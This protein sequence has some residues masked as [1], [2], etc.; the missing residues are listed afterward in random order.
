MRLL[1]ISNGINPGQTFLAHAT[2]W[3]RDV[4]AG[5]TTAVF[6]PFA[7]V[8]GSWDDYTAAVAAVLAPMG[9]QVEGLHAVADPVAA[10]NAAGT[11]LVGGGNTFHLIRTLHERGLTMAITKRARA[12]TPYI[13][14]SAGANIACPT[15]RTT[16]DM[17]IVEPL[18]LRACGLVPFQ[19][20]PHY[21]D[22]HPEGHSG[23]TR[24]D[25]IL[26][27]IEV[28]RTVSVVGL[29]EGSALRVAGDKLRLLGPKPA[30]IFR[31]GAEPREVGPEDSLQDLMGG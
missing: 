18:S 23:E 8:R 5:V 19:I 26:E 28:N 15:I 31:H 1:L 7:S 17:P 21:L 13:G 25:R 30:R 11:I 24:A 22:V 14:W 16:N 10:V 6:A 3:I 9:V 4:L 12:G 2:D 29:R 20:N 27:F